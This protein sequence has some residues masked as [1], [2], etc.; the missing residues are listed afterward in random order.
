[1]SK[2]MCISFTW[3]SIRSLFSAVEKVDRFVDIFVDAA[4]DFKRIATERDEYFKAM[5]SL[6]S[7]V[8]ELSANKIVLETKLY[9]AEGKEEKMISRLTELEGS[10]QLL[11][12]QLKEAET[13]S[14]ER[15]TVIDRLR[16]LIDP[17]R[18]AVTDMGI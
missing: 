17:L 11:R 3:R 9:D 5:E 2:K 10:I 7:H 14:I 12:N 16:S 4:N 6:E 1:M 18:K 15:S 8:R 13:R